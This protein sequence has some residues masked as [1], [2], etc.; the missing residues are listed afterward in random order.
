MVLLKA[1]GHHNHFKQYRNGPSPELTM[2]GGAMATVHLCSPEKGALA[3]RGAVNPPASCQA[4]RPCMTEGT[5][6]RN[7]CPSG[8]RRAASERLPHLL[9]SRSLVLRGPVR[10]KGKH[11]L[12]PAASCLPPARPRAWRGR[13]RG[14]LLA[15]SGAAGA[16]KVLKPQ[17]LGTRDSSRGQGTPS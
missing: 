4:C 12:L 13:A 1:S 17:W 15:C 11:P 7:Q 10:E 2:E 3:G 6:R 8:L 14:L 9:S 16:W 5:L